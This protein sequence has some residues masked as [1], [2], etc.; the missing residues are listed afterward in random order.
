MEKKK[1]YFTISPELVDIDGIFETNGN[2]TITCYSMQ[3]NEPYKEFDFVTAIAG[4][5]QDKIQDY[6][7][8]N[9]LIIEDVEFEFIFL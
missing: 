3:N 9:D 2:Q 8:D 6:L 7:E 5:D 4:D 1:L